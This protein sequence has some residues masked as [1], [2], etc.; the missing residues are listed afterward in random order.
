MPYHIP[1]NRLPLVFSVLLLLPLL[2]LSLPP[3]HAA[4]QQQDHWLGLKQ[5]VNAFALRSEAVGQADAFLEY[6]G[7]GSVVF[8]QGP[9]DALELYASADFQDAVHELSWRAHYIDV[10]RDGDLGLSAGPYLMI[11]ESESAQ[12]QGQQQQYGH[13]VSVW[14]KVD[15]R[16][17]LMADLGAPIPGYLSLQVEA[18]YAHTQQ[19][20]AEAAHPLMA[21]NGANDRARLLEADQVYGRAINFR[22]GQRALL[23]HGLDNIRVYLP[24]LAPT[25]G[26]EAASSVYGAFLDSQLYTINPIQLE[27]K[28]GYLSTSQEMGY[29]YGIMSTAIGEGGSGFRTNYLRVWRLTDGNEWKIAV[30]VLNPY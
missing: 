27:Q 29:T 1:M 11:D 9:E 17:L 20:M 30:E 10:S 2:L 26:V 24:G 4:E 8:W 13:L 5:T 22:G 21:M 6:L 25:V 16:W 7:P 3:A 14:H 28:G 12:E 19:V 15:G 23:R 18:D